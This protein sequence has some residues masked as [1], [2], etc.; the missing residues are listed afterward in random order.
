M[1][2]LH[3]RYVSEK[4]ASCAPLKAILMTKAGEGQL[5]IVVELVLRILFRSHDKIR[6]IMAYRDYFHYEA[7]TL[8]IREFFKGRR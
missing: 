7:C 2:Y 6:M 8:Q 1:Q 4:G 3:V 5:S